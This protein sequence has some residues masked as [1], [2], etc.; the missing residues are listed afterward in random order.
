MKGKE[1]K[2]LSLI[3]K[4]VLISGLS[5]SIMILILLFIFSSEVENLGKTLTKNDFKSA[6]SI[7]ESMVET[8]ELVKNE[9]KKTE[10]NVV[11]KHLIQ[12]VENYASL[13]KYVF[14]KNKNLSLTKKIDE[15]RPYLQGKVVGKTGYLV[16]CDLSGKII[17]HKVKKTEGISLAK[18]DFFQEI[19]RKVENGENEGVIYYKWKNPG[20]TRWRDKAL[21][22]IFFP[23]Y[24]IYLFATSY[25]DEFSDIVDKTFYEKVDKSF[26][27]NFV[28]IKI[29]KSGYSVLISK[30]GKMLLH[31]KKDLIGK[32][33]S[34]DEWFKKIQSF[35]KKGQKEGFFEYT[36]NGINK[37]MYFKYI[38]QKEAFAALAAPIEDVYGL[39]V[40]KTIFS[41]IIIGLF[42]LVLSSTV[43]FI[44]TKKSLDP[45]RIMVNILKDVAR[46]KGDLTK[47]L[48]VATSDEIGEVSKYFN[49]FVENMR[50][51]IREI[52]S[53]SHT[54]SSASTEIAA[55]I[56][57]LAQ[58]TNES[59]NLANNVASAV[60]EMTASVVEIAESTKKIHEMAEAL[61]NE[62]N[63]GSQIVDENMN[64]IQEINTVTEKAVNLISVLKESTG[65]IT[66]IVKFIG[67]IADQ[68]NLLALNAA[69][70]AAR[71][72]EH[73][74]GFAVVADEV[75]KLAEKTAS[76]IKEVDG[77][78]K[79]I[80]KNIE[81][82]INSISTINKMVE[83]AVTEFSKVKESSLRTIERAKNLKDISAHV[84]TA[85]NEQT[86]AAD[87][88]SNNITTIA[89]S[90]NE[91]NQALG[92]TS[93]AVADLS[94][95]AEI[96]NTMVKKFKT[97]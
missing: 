97:E 65:K 49:E 46:G 36:F 43:L 93:K 15:L 26:E 48:K 75:R 24:K 92:Q 91:I 28:K 27:S 34:N 44:F 31:P 80:G 47:R 59:A 45:I 23:N 22:Y 56:E 39:A 76:S 58:S 9:Y 30:D 11:E 82:T 55:S 88:I 14:E 1:S 51:M 74:R 10:K 37:V 61:E 79:E 5:L 78:N 84:S 89:Q 54:V 19:K 81:I 25:I 35:M 85:T 60:E 53:V 32:D 50:N 12:L 38:P 13:V 95:Q 66:E 63:E 96:L 3:S 69:I 4:L 70:E 18:F 62:G 33:F 16:I 17:F 40:K 67:E 2:G 64:R 29:G 57:E 21:S 42:L 90:I 73:G 68:T 8:S 7:I 71:A 6:I 41:I 87:E 77:V 86:V 83:T 94:E 20:E 72:G 52:S